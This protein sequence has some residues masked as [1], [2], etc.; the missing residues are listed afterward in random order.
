[1]WAHIT[2]ARMRS[3]RPIH[4][5]DTLWYE[6]AVSVGETYAIAVNGPEDGLTIADRLAKANNASLRWVS[7]WTARP[8]RSEFTVHFGTRLVS[9]SVE[10]EWM[11]C[12]SDPTIDDVRYFIAHAG[13][14]PVCIHFS[15]PLYVSE[16]G[17][18]APWISFIDSYGNKRDDAR[19]YGFELAGNAI[20]LTTSDRPWDVSFIVGP[21][22]AMGWE[23]RLKIIRDHIPRDELVHWI[24]K[25]CSVPLALIREV[26][27]RTTLRPARPASLGPPSPAPERRRSVPADVQSPHGRSD[28]T[29]GSTEVGA[30]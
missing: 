30:S 17:P 3:R 23:L 18:G 19:V 16:G 8:M 7:L 14:D 13:G 12:V 25:A 4:T 2:H 27:A 28:A 22:A 1:M 20:P 5:L 29:P 6:F 15:P 21:T 26:A 11:L 24:A 9:Q 10:K